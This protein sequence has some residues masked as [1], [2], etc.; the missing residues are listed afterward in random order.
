VKGKTGRKRTRRKPTIP[1]WKLVVKRRFQ[2]LA[3]EAGSQRKLA[4]AWLGD[5]GRAHMISE[6]CS[7]SNSTLPDTENLIRLRENLGVSIDWLFTPEGSGLDANGWPPDR[8]STLS[9]ELKHY[10][11]WLSKATRHHGVVAAARRGSKDPKI[12]KLTDRVQR[13][14]DPKVLPATIDMMRGD[15]LEYFGRRIEKLFDE[16]AAAL[17]Q[18]EGIRAAT[19]WYA[20]RKAVAAQLGQPDISDGYAVSAIRD[21]IESAKKEEG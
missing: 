4:A 15:P 10:V 7:E 19:L 11:A 21:L 8:I 3:E 14:S 12:I 17:D 6:W 2:K 1:E 5:A 20:L 16:A 9:A 13:W 18:L